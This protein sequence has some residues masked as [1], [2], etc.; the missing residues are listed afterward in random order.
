M[1][2]APQNVP[3][4]CPPGLQYLT[5]VDQLL[6]KQK[7]EILEAVTGFETQNKYKVFNSLGQQVYK[8]KEDSDC[9]TR[10]CCGPARCF[11]L[12]ITD[13]Q[14]QEVIH[15]NRPLRC[16]A[17]CF[18]CCLQELEV[19]SPPGSIIGTVELLWRCRLQCGHHG[20]TRGWQDHQAVEWASQRSF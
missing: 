19:S 5:M 4:G 6:V 12:N 14:E 15:L 13:M 18:P 3:V 7:V 1:M 16:Q 20:W 17:C 11:D 10:Q 8:A 9:C 2:M